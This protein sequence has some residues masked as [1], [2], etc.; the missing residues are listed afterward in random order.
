MYCYLS[1]HSIPKVLA[2]SA[3]SPARIVCL[4]D[5]N[6]SLSV[7][8]NRYAYNSTNMQTELGKIPDLR[9]PFKKRDKKNNLVD[10]QIQ[11]SLGAR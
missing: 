3:S 1:F 7:L 8:K 4:C 11:A 2:K 9:L 10:S 5:M 6:F